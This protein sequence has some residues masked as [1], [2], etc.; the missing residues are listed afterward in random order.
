M[1]EWYFNL[2]KYYRIFHKL[3]FNLLFRVKILKYQKKFNQDY[4]AHLKYYKKYVYNDVSKN[5]K[6]NYY[7]FPFVR[8]YIM[9]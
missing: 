3:V 7:H 8:N 4:F 1:I 9:L 2:L 6:L 5:K